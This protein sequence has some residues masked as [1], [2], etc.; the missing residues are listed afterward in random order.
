MKVR[1]YATAKVQGLANIEDLSPGVAK[2]V[3]ARSLGE[4]PEIR[5]PD[6]RLRHL[7]CDHHPSK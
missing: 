6:R 3:D 7:P 1:S 5:L 4:L 2:E